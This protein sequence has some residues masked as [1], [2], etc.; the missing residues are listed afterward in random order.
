M[1]IT[2]ST[3][4]II[5]EDTIATVPWECQ[6]NFRLCTKG[7]MWKW[8]KSVRIYFTCMELYFYKLFPIH[9][10]LF[11][12]IGTFI[13]IISRFLKKEYNNLHSSEL[14]VAQLKVRV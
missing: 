11:T 3:T 7:D 14:K 13:Q 2:K 12:A 8:C 10:Q 6:L 4:F 9:R 1:L 5:F